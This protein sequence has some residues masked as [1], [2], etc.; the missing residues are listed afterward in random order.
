MTESL[1]LEMTATYKGQKEYLAK[2][3]RKPTKIVRK[4]S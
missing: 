1:W 4:T 2:L 3:L